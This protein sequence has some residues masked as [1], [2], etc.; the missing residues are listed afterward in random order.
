MRRAADRAG[1][2]GASWHTLRYTCASRL[3]MRGVSLRIV[4]AILGHASIRQTEIYA[5]LAPGYARSRRGSATRGAPGARVA[6]TR[7]KQRP[8]PSRRGPCTDSTLAVGR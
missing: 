7:Q 8:H 6:S 4:Q 2:K 3:V 5:H 1:L